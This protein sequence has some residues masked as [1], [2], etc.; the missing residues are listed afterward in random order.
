M[1]ILIIAMKPPLGKSLPIENSAFEPVPT[2]QQISYPTSGAGFVRTP[3]IF[4]SVMYFSMSE[5]LI[6]EK[7]PGCPRC[8]I[9]NGCHRK[10]SQ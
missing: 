3:V 9:H 5:F 10:Y 2:I 8:A 4:L 6:L 1:R 7:G